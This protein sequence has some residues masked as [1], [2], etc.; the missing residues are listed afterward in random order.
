[1]SRLCTPLRVLVALSLA[2]LAL[3]LYAA[4][5]VGFGDAEALYAAYALHPQ[6]SYLDHPGLVG[7]VARLL[8]GGGAPSP[9]AAHLATSLLATLV[10]WLGAFAARFA[11]A[12]WSR[13]P[14]A[15]LAL[16]SAPELTVGLFGMTPDALL[17]PLW[18]VALGAIANALRASVGSPRATFSFLLAGAAIGLGADAKVSALLLVPAAAIAVIRSPHA[19]SLGPLLGLALA[20]LLFSPVALFEARSGFPMLAH[21]FVTTQTGAGLSLRNAGALVGGQ[22][23]Y[24][25]PLVAA[26]AAILVVRTARGEG[27]KD[28]RASD[29]SAEWLRFATLVPLVPL[30]AL[31]LWSRVA[32]PH[33]LAPALLA[34][35]L[36]LARGDQALPRAVR[37]LALPT[38]LAMSLAAHAWALTELAPRWLGSA[39]EARYDLANDLYAAKPL[40]RS[41]DAAVARATE[42]SGV[43]PVVVAAH[44]TVAAQ[45]AAALGD[46]PITTTGD[47]DFARWLPRSRWERRPA[48]VWVTD[49]RFDASPPPAWT[50]AEESIVPLVRGGRVVRRARVLVLVRATTASSTARDD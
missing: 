37:A 47:D 32:E 5:R 20:G 7:S 1:M 21:R 40:A 50:T 45:L 15:G 48:I 4:T 6:P 31:C 29:P 26:G 38:G 11:G 44:W 16:A 17:A 43:P 42:L 33:W 9:L 13:S 10:P 23:A 18:I 30:A 34:L 14:I 22:L 49:D 12:P 41:V 28:G 46:V 36:A 27:G 2:L 35:P 8:G 24:L 19:R 39:Y 3:R 25:S